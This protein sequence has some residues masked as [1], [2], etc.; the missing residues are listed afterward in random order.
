MIAIRK[1]LSRTLTPLHRAADVRSTG[2]MGGR[3]TTAETVRP[4]EPAVTIGPLGWLVPMAVLA[5]Y[6]AWM[7]LSPSTGTDWTRICVHALL[8]ALWCRVGVEWLAGRC[9][10]V[11][12]AT[13]PGGKRTAD[14]GMDTDTHVTEDACS[15]EASSNC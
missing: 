9:A 1:R 4:D 10:E 12:A 6:L 13:V 15:A 5:L 7:G 2:Q 14:L 3:D 11:R 8:L